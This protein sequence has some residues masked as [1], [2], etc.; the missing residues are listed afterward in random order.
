MVST[1]KSIPFRPQVN[2]VKQGRANEGS[3][4]PDVQTYENS[5]YRHKVTDHE[6][7]RDIENQPVSKVGTGI[8][9]KT[10]TNGCTRFP[11]KL[12][13]PSPTGNGRSAHLTNKQAVNLARAAIHAW[14]INLPLNRLLTIHWEAAGVKDEQA[15]RATSKMIKLISDWLSTRG[16]QTAWIWVRENGLREGSHVHIAIHV[17]I[18]TSLGPKQQRWL[19]RITGIKYRKGVI[20]TRCIGRSAKAA[21]SEPTG[22]SI[23]MLNVVAYLLKGINPTSAKEIG[24]LRCSPTGVIVGKRSA[25]SQ[26]VGTKA[27]NSISSSKRTLIIQSLS[28]SPLS[29]KSIPKRFAHRLRHNWYVL[30]VP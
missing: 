27:R 24:L 21:F 18:D 23:N 9:L 11:P 17:P 2:P 29:A 30:R 14:E 6:V 7:H 3:I 20:K 5:D 13:P 22:Y 10:N 1:S 28:T 15:G 12:C 25:T 26:N 19:R 4:E 8:A 16:L